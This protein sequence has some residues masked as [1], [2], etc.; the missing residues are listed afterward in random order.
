MKLRYLI[1]LLCLS[2]LAFGQEAT[3]YGYVSPTTAAL[4]PAQ[5]ANPKQDVVIPNFK[6]RELPV[7]L[8]SNAHQPDWVW[9]QHGSNNNQKTTSASLLWQVQGIGNGISPPDPS[10]E[11]DS[12][13]Y[14]QGTNAGSGG[15]YKIFNKTTGAAVS[16][17]LVM[18]SLSS[19]TVTGLGDPVILYYKSAKRWIITQ[20]STQ[21]QKKLLVYVSQTSNPQGA[22]YFY[23]FTCPNF[24]DYPKWSI[25]E[26]SDAL[27]AST[28]EGGPPRVYAMKLSALVTGATSPFIGVA[29]GYTLNGFGFQSI[30]PVD[31]EG[32]FPAPAGQKPLFVRHRDDEKHSN[33]SPDSPTNDW[34]EIWE[35]TINW[36]NNTGSVAKI[37]DV[38]I[39]E[40][41]SDLC[42]LTSF[43]CIAQ[44]GT[45][46]KLDPLRECVM[47]KA[48]MRVFNDHQAMALCLATDVNGNN[49]AGVRWLELRRPTGSTGSWSLYQEGTYAPGTTL[50]RW[51][52]AINIDKYGNIMLAYSTSGTTAPDYPSIQMTGRKACDPLGQMTLPEM[53]IKQGMSARTSN[54]RWGDYHHMCV[55]DFDG[56]TFYYTGVVMNS[57]NNIVT[58]V[59][60]FKMNPDSLDLAILSAFTTQTGG[61]CGASTQIAVVV[62]N[63]GVNTVNSFNLSGQVGTGNPTNQSYTSTSLTGYQLI[64]TVYFTAAGLQPGLNTLQLQLSNI[65]GLGNDENTCNDAYNLELTV[66]GSTSVAVNA[67]ITQQPSCNA[68]N[69]TVQ[70]QTTG[71][72]GPYTYSL[73]NAT[74]Q[75]S[76]TFTN[77]GA[78]NYTYT[79]FDNQ[80][81][82]VSG[83]F[84]ITATTTIAANIVQT[85]TI[86]CAGSQT[87]NLVVTPSG[88]TAPYSYSIDNGAD[89]ASNTFNN[90]GA[91]TYTIGVIDANGCFTTLTYIVT[92]PSPLSVNMI[93]TMISCNGANDGA[94]NCQVSGGTSPYLYAIN[95]GAVTSSAVFSNLPAGSYTLTAIDANGCQQG[96]TSTI[97]EPTAISLTAS[98]T[99]SNGNDGTISLSASGGNSPYT[100]SMDG[101]TYY[102]GSFFASLAIGTYTCYV[103]DNNGCVTT[104]EVTVNSSS[105]S[106]LSFELMTL[107]PNPN[108]G[109]F[110]V[111]IE[112]VIGATLD[113]KLF[114]SLG[115]QISSFTMKAVHGKAKETITL[116][117]KIAA[118]SY[119]LGIY[120]EGKGAVL[121]FIKE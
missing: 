17:T 115:Q 79:V 4:V 16:G 98:T 6:G 116:S 48:P 10:G 83:T 5:S 47:Y 75:S 20:F 57:N 35:M 100:Y 15:S 93:P 119:F 58:N 9:Q 85:T 120:D 52:P 108:S 105:L 63:R 110:E 91:G 103:K 90:L 41:D 89:Q 113:A 114:N 117:P 76:N 50:N 97:T 54:T 72:S 33:G 71:S 77:L 78:G 107:Y 30:T 53:V 55:D 11:A 49:R 2:S 96:F 43:S 8:S 34:I 94:L 65:N 23:Q 44:P 106:E 56:L 29:I 22:Y 80:G 87:A 21:A 81:C 70:L 95:G 99:V 111:Q 28:N 26:S 39:T 66:I 121:Q 74:P 92:Q 104:I 36:T 82:A 64:D 68:S 37:Q 32:D 19:P 112:G 40:I 51:M 27:L 13:V 46:V 45:T 59:S 88:G 18:A 69:G 73:D 118:G 1:G 84:S 7:Q 101:Q 38:P 109:V 3:F 12:T 61:I 14:I 31:L 67:T 86:A 102:S 25:S 42:G 62:E 24:P 60:A